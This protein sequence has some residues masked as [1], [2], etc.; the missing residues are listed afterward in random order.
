MPGRVVLQLCWTLF[1]IISSF[2]LTDGADTEQRSDRKAKG[3]D[4]SIF[5]SG[6]F[7]S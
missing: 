3:I 7:L 4:F 1:V 5:M 2:N 6:F